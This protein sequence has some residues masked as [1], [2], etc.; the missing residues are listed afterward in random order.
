ML[1]CAG[2]HDNQ[3]LRLFSYYLLK[4]FHS[5]THKHTH[6]HT[7]AQ[8]VLKTVGHKWCIAEQHSGLLQALQK[9]NISPW[10]S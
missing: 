8:S 7:H 9:G 1:A 4:T 6:T 2:P 5:H 10:M 3:L